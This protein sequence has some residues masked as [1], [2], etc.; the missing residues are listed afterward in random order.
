L[1]GS[2]AT[3]FT[4][5]AEDSSETEAGAARR[6]LDSGARALTRLGV[7]TETVVGRGDLLESLS[8]HLR[9]DV[10]LLVLGA[11]L[12]DEEGALRWGRR[13]G[14]LLA[15]A[16]ARPILVV[17]SRVAGRGRTA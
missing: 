2:S 8:E 7:P 5:L 11:P 10:D 6:F 12:P 3:L 14:Q 17:R 15:L 16:G 4:A 13:S 1:L 9:G